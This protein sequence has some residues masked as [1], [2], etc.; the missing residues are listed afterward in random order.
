MESKQL[1]KNIDKLSDM[2]N[3]YIFEMYHLSRKYYDNENISTSSFP[4]TYNIASPL[5]K[6]NNDVLKNNF[7]IYYGTVRP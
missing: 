2:L 3:N 5:P 7:N 1:N 6:P 4:I